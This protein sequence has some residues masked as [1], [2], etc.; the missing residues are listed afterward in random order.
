MTTDDTPPR[1]LI[2]LATAVINWVLCPCLPGPRPGQCAGGG[3]GV[4]TCGEA[5]VLELQTK[6][7]EEG[8]PALRIYANQPNR[9]ICVVR[10]L[11]NVG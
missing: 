7:R 4:R 5:M 1:P 3:R 8:R 9:D 11:N 10:L 2:I 6:V